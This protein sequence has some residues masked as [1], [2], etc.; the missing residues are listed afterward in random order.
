M[1]SQLA[2]VT[3]AG[4]GIGQATALA[5]AEA[6]YRLALLGRREAPLLAAQA[7]LQ[8]LG[9][10]ACTLA[11]DVCDR[12]ALEQALRPLGPIQ[13]LVANAG[14]CKRARLDDDDS[15]RIWSEILDTNLNGVWH[16]LRAVVPAM[17]VDGRVVAVSSGLGKLGRAG[18]S[19][20]AA[21]KHGLLGLVKCL[22]LELAPQGITVNAVCPGWV[23]T[24]MAAADLARGDVDPDR[25]KAEALAGIPLGRFVAPQEVA[26]L[27][28]WLISPA[29]AAITG[30][31]Y[32][33]SA[34]EF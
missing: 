14:I 26:A 10:E 22:A 31:A 21:S 7:Q 30:Q 1:R 8:Q 16:T 17:P 27:I 32:N 5:L 13:A 19:A 9:A 28:A 4:S 18:Y 15:D 29:A 23:D 2:L 12:S 24:D 20:Y 34:G 3:G 6:G 25:A 33:I 11:V